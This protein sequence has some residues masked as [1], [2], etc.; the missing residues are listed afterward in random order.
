MNKTAQTTPKRIK[1]LKQILKKIKSARERDRIRALIKL[2]EG[3]KRKDVA[4]FLDINVKT[5]DR[6]ISTFKKQGIKGLLDKK[7]P[8]NHRLLTKK[9]RN[10]VKAIITAN[11]PE[12]LSLEGKFW[13]VVSLKQLVK[14]D[15]K[16][17]YRSET[18]LRNLF[19]YCGFTFH[20][21]VRVNT[22]QN[23]HM[24]RR[25][26]DVLKKRSDGTVEKIVW[27]W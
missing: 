2:A 15:F 11:K 3:R 14:R 24:R 17:N 12:D 7:Q 1:E 4:N 22:K 8:G 19:K 18:S 27:Y 13:N 16:V 10:K 5:L 25:F 21:P 23:S 9:Q 26:E 20:K 6:W